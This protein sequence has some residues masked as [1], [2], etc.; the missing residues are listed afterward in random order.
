MN[1]EKKDVEQDLE[2]ELETVH[3]SATEIVAKEKDVE[4][5]PQ[6]AEAKK[7]TEEEE[8]KLI[9]DNTLGEFYD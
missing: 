3:A 2:E 6:K 7:L 5:F 9:E 4:K 8:R 1:E